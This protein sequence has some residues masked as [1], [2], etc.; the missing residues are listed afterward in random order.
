MEGE[1]P[2]ATSRQNYEAEV[3]DAVNK[4]ILNELNAFY[5]YAAMVSLLLW[6]C[7]LAS[8]I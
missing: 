8:F 3:E 5:Q 4:Q 7:A 2:I 6:F 1:Q